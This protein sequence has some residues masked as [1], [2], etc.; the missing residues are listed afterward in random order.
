MG[1]GWNSDK[2]NDGR[3]ARRASKPCSRS[4]QATACRR[5]ISGTRPIAAT[6][7]CASAA[8][9]CGS[10]RAARSA[11]NRWS[12]CS[13][14]C[15]ARTRTAGITSSRRSRRSM[16]A[17][18]DAPFLAVEMEVSGEGDDQVLTFRTNVDDVVRCERH[19]SAP[20]RGEP[21]SGGLKPY[22]LVRGRLEA[23]VTRAVYYDLV[24][25]AVPGGRMPTLR[26]ASGAAASFFAGGRVASPRFTTGDRGDQPPRASP[27]IV[28]NARSRG[29]QVGCAAASFSSVI[30][31]LVR[32]MHRRV[33]SPAC[34]AALHISR[35]PRQRHD[36]SREQ[37]PG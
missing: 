20:L 3:G 5:W 8:T 2:Q 36:G 34:G 31:G 33:R 29:L 12:G 7:A 21:H 37:V 16:S 11:A 10:T 19:A 9:A 26:S 32:A 23:L 15:C 1:N 22:L 35:S 6:S 24:E 18:D 14:A 25:L 17:V 28:R 13:R 30:P 4:R 27:A